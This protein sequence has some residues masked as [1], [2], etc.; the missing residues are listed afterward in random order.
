MT[1][2]GDDRK[3]TG[4]NPEEKISLAEALICYTA[5]SAYAYDMEDELGTLEAGKLADIIVID[6]NMFEIPDDEIPECNVRYTFFNGDEI[7]AAE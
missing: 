6:R 2:N 5:N 3:P 4:V 1:R 7:Y